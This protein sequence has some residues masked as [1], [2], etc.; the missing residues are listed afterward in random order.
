MR[1]FKPVV[2]Q[3]KSP[4]HKA[5][6]LPPPKTPPVGPPVYRPQLAPK[7]LQLKPRAL[8][9]KSTN[10]RS[11]V[12]QRLEVKIPAYIRTIAEERM[13]EADGDWDADPRE[14]PRETSSWLRREEHGRQQARQQFERQERIRLWQEEQRRL[15]Q[16]RE[17]QF[18]WDCVH[19]DEAVAQMDWNGNWGP[20][21]RVQGNLDRL[22]LWAEHKYH[23]KLIPI[24][25]RK[26]FYYVGKL[27]N[28][29]KTG[30]RISGH[31]KTDPSKSTTF[32]V[33]H[34]EK[35]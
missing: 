4:Q 16:Q 30:F 21:V 18:H 22:R 31:T 28:W 6:Q 2:A 7:C 15:Y 24:R 33:L 34:I 13:R 10:N 17:A 23:H 32:G 27:R 25:S 20:T 11:A 35:E 29:G 12:V 1:Q 5:A 14:V 19:I 9:A 26:L 8:Q 3:L